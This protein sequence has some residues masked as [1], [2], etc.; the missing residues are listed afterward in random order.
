M[1]GSQRR[2]VCPNCGKVF[3]AWRP[4][5]APGA[6]FK[7]YFCKHEAEDEASKRTAPPAPAPPAPEPKTASS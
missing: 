4:D 7:C 5:T 1:S 2:Q 3:F 6:K